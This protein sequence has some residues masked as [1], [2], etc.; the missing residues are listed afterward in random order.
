MGRFNVGIIAIVGLVD[1]E[2]GHEL[3]LLWVVECW[4]YCNRA[5]L[6]TR[7]IRT[8]RIGTLHVGIIAIVV[9]HWKGYSSRH[10]FCRL[11]LCARVDSIWR[12]RTLKCMSCR[13]CFPPQP[14]DL[15]STSFPS[16]LSEPTPLPISEPFQNPLTPPPSRPHTPLCLPE[17]TPT[18]R[19][20]THPIHPTH[21]FES[22]FL[23]QQWSRLF[24][25]NNESSVC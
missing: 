24:I 18:S 8:I 19:P 17:P 16:S 25:C 13:V 5:W 22:V 4:H 1:H 2:R 21:V 11:N 23:P 6:I 10:G 14:F 20:H 7:S 3:P 12:K 9:Y 15:L